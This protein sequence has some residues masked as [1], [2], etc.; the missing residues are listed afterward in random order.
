V[1]R[2]YRNGPVEIKGDIKIPEGKNVVLRFDID[3]DKY[4][5]IR[6]K[7]EEGLSGTRTIHVFG[8]GKEL[9]MCEKV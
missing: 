1:K 7:L 9:V 5:G 4:W 2:E 6:T 3:P 8:F